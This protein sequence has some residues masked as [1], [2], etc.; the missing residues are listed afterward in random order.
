MTHS[1]V[2]Y[3]LAKDGFH[4]DKNAIPVPNKTSIDLFRIG[5]N[6]SDGKTGLRIGKHDTEAEMTE[7]IK[8]LE[9]DTAYC[10]R[11]TNAIAKT[12]E[13]PSKLS[14]RYTRP[15]EKYEVLFPA[16]PAAGK[17]SKSGKSKAALRQED[18]TKYELAVSA[19]EKAIF[20]K[21]SVMNTEVRDKP[22][23]LCLFG[24]NNISI[25]RAT[26]NWVISSLLSVQFDAGPQWSFRHNGNLDPQFRSFFDQLCIALYRKHGSIPLKGVP[27][28]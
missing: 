1:N 28:S 22:I 10:E 26:R 19:A 8:R 11:I 21:Q 16:K 20:G 2:F 7:H 3:I 18:Q 9:D 27:N 25:P 12:S 14:P 6:I 23:L 15:D 24:E 4:A 5:F 17:R 13:D